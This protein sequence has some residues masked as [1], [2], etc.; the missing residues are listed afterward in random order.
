MKQIGF[1]Y[2]ITK[3]GRILVKAEL[4]PKLNTEVFD[5][6]SNPIGIVIDVL[7]PVNSPYVAVKPYKKVDIQNLKNQKLYVK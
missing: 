5:K 2:N 6:D 7:G 4:V 3:R 1:V